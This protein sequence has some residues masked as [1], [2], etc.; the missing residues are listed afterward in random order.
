V[1]LPVLRLTKKLYQFLIA[2][3]FGI[4]NVVLSSL[5]AL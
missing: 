1:P 3:L 4:L 2:R 5:G